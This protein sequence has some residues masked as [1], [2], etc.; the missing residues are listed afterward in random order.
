MDIDTAIA[1]LITLRESS[2]KA[3]SVK[4]AMDC[5][6]IFQSDIFKAKIY[7]KEYPDEIRTGIKALLK[8]G[9]IIM[10]AQRNAAQADINKIQATLEELN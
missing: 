4:G 1:K 8:A 3:E 10:D 7:L 5:E 6:I 9:S 2:A